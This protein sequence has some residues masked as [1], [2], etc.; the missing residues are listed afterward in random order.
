MN[1][2]PGAKASEVLPKSLEKSHSLPKTIRRLP[3]TCAGGQAVGGLGQRSGAGM[4][5]KCLVKRRRSWLKKV[6]HGLQAKIEP[7]VWKR[8]SMRVGGLYLKRAF[9]RREAFPVSVHKWVG[10]ANAI[11]WRVKFSSRR[12]R[13][14]RLC[15][16]PGLQVNRCPFFNTYFRQF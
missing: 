14:W 2:P 4:A 12:R 13:L 9:K 3:S 10:T 8:G 6:N 7:R 5:L 16:N 1:L 11:G 15:Q